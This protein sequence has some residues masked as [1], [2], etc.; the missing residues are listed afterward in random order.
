[1][2]YLINT[3]EDTETEGTTLAHIAQFEGGGA[4]I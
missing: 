3:L 4:Q 2:Y 1:M